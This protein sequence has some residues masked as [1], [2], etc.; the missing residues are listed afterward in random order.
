M[1]KIIIKTIISTLL[2]FIL[3]IYVFF[4]SIVGLFDLTPDI[5]VNKNTITKAKAKVLKAKSKLKKGIVK[6]ASG[7]AASVFTQA[8]VPI[9]LV[10]GGIA[11]I[12]VIGI[13][14]DEYCETQNTLNNIFLILENKD[15]K[16]M[17][18]SQ[19]KDLIIN[20]AVQVSSDQGNDFKKWANSSYEDSSQWLS[21]KYGNT[22]TW[23]S[24]GYNMSEGW[25][26]DQ[27]SSTFDSD[28]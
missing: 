19:C 12:T 24:D 26:A 10:G 6:R 28:K 7:R 22:S 11:A 13:S 20:D 16:D 15:E 2:I 3:I 27:W 5:D 17:N 8:A 14:A 25:I 18:I 23:V 21:E 1:L 9:P 4:N